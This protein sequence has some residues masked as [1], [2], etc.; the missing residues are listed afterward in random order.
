M[1]S[2]KEIVE[3]LKQTYPN[4]M[5]K[6][7]DNSEDA[8][9]W[10]NRKCENFEKIFDGICAKKDRYAEHWGRITI[11]YELETSDKPVIFSFFMYKMFDV[12][13]CSF[14]WM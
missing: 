13:K 8:L 2:S 3:I 12:Y 5:K 1:R 4:S 11:T 14:L 7:F 9:R 10:V 6:S